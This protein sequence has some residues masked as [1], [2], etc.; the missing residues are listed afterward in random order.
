MSRLFFRRRL[1]AASALSLLPW[2]PGCA[3]DDK[4]EGDRPSSGQPPSDEDR[5]R[6]ARSYGDEHLTSQQLDPRMVRLVARGVDTPH[7]LMRGNAPIDGD[8]FEYDALIDALRQAAGD[9]WPARF[10]IVDVSLMNEIA[11]ATAVDAERRYWAA[12]PGRGRFIH[13]PLFGALSDPADY[14]AFLRLMIERWSGLDRMGDLLRQLQ[15][16]LQTPTGDGIA[17]VVFVHCRAG[18][19]RTGQAIA[20]YGMRYLGRSYREAIADAEQV[21]GRALVRF[22]RYGIAWY[23]HQLADRD[24]V[25]TIGPIP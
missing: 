21:A 2:L 24:Q 10:R 16:L 8:R 17:N 13:H 23:A 6:L 1:L 9:A 7:L 19:D 3:G 22:S 11:E 12:H 18:R 25:P 20:S 4:D 5:D 15:A 14:P